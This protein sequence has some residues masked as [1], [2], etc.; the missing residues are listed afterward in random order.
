MMRACFLVEFVRIPCSCCGI[1]GTLGVDP[2]A[3]GAVSMTRLGGQDS[4]ILIASYVYL[5]RL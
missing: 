1:G 5:F 4:V 3:R 2:P